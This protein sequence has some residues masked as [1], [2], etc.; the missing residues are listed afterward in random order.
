MLIRSSGSEKLARTACKGKRIFVCFASFVHS[1]SFRLFLTFRVFRLFR[2]QVLP[3][4]FL[5]ST[6]VFQIFSCAFPSLFHASVLFVYYI[7]RGLFLTF[8]EYLR[9]S[10]SLFLTVQLTAPPGEK[11]RRDYNKAPGKN[12]TARRRAV[13]RKERERER[14]ISGQK[15]HFLMNS[16]H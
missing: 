9:A 1:D 8:S 4:H 2:L 7:F 16:V 6:A 15:T 3:K 10:V 12:K 14:D 11:A 13:P 5:T